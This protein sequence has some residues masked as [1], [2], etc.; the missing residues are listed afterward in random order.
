MTVW[1]QSAGA[2]ASGFSRDFS[3]RQTAWLIV[4]DQLKPDNGDPEQEQRD[5][6]RGKRVREVKAIGTRIEAGQEPRQTPGGRKP[7][8]QRDADEHD[9][10][11]ADNPWHWLGHERGLA[12]AGASGKRQSSSVAFD[13]TGPLSEPTATGN[14]RRARAK[15]TMR[16]R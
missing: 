11:N 12:E 1:R 14:P 7:V 9:A 16:R 4:R 2:I 8:D 13:W 3:A 6:K 10:D 15:A 5:D